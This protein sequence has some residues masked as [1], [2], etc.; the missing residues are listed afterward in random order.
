MA[1]EGSRCDHCNKV[2]KI[3]PIG[4]SQLSLRFI[5][6]THRLS[7]QALDGVFPKVVDSGGITD[8]KTESSNRAR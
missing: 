2:A 4:A 3:D 8:L 7:F 5:G 6:A 1:V